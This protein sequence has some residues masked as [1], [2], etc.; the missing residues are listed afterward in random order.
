MTMN[1]S[2]LRIVFMGT[3]EFAL[4]SLTMLIKEGY[5]IVGV[6]T[7]P[8]KPKGRGHKLLPPP[9]KELAIKN[10]IQ[11]LQPLKVSRDGFDELKALDANLFITVAFGQILSRD[12]LALPEY[13]C[14]NVHGSLL[15]KY[16]GAAP[17]EWAVIN[18]EKEAGVTTMY[19]VYE[20]DAGD[21]LLKSSIEVPDDMTGGELREKLSFLGAEV[22]KETLL[23][24]IDGT[25]Q[26]EKQNEEEMTYYP[27][28][29]RELSQIDWS[30]SAKSIKDLVRALNPS[31]PAYAFFGEDKVKIFETDIFDMTPKAP[32][33]VMIADAKKGLFISAGDG[34]LE[35]KR[36][37][38]P[39]GKPM[40]AKELLRGRPNY[41]KAEV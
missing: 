12:V 8:D 34:V 18:G 27:I 14:I 5:N 33:T 16:R 28:P 17:I 41:F 10:G 32:G 40:S 7:Q 35:I 39:G 4:P 22:L 1:K 6:V 26:S 25:L 30:K 24:L 38:L 21:M 9:V 37:Q 29:T 13:G 36:L 2:D 23:R 3:P 19:T 20:L 31:Q 11:V 15:P